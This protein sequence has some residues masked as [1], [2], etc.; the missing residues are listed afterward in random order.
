LILAGLVLLTIAPIG[1]VADRP[2]ALLDWGRSAVL[3]A[4]VLALLM[5]VS[6]FTAYVSPLAAGTD[7]GGSEMS[8]TGLTD[9][10]ATDLAAT[11]G[12][13][14]ED[15]LL[16]TS[17]GDQE[18]ARGLA[19]ALWFSA[20]ITLVVLI[21]QARGRARPGTWTVT[22]G[23]LG[24]APVV[25]NGT[26]TVPLTAGLLAFGVGADVVT[27]RARPHAVS[28]G[29]AVALMWAAYFAALSSRG[30]L[31][32]NRQLWAGV[33]ATGLL[34]GSA[35][36][37]AVRWLTGPARSPSQVPDQRRDHGASGPAQAGRRFGP[38]ETRTVVPP[39]PMSGRQPAPSMAARRYPSSH[40]ASRSPGALKRT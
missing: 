24:L 30:D 25:V 16:G 5:V 21:A 37:G 8:H 20:L 28:F 18:T 2:G 15:P 1:G 9:L 23:L 4:S 40:G 38:A 29:A 32:W 10:S 14:F 11:S 17:T 22:F 12:I 19:S 34:A 26:N 3:G 36:A 27:L 6:L 35:A 39:S 13:V 33:I 31:M 7:L